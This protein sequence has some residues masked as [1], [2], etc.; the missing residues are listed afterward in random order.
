MPH[1]LAVFGRVYKG[2]EFMGNKHT[3]N[4]LYLYIYVRINSYK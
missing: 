3:N 1:G 4:C 2:A